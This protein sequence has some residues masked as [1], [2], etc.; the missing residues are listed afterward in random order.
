MARPK[1]KVLRLPPAE[2]SF[3]ELNDSPEILV[4]VDEAHRSHTSALHANLMQA[5]PNCA[6]IGFTGTPILKK[7]KKRTQDIFGPFIDCYTIKQSEADGATV[8]IIYEGRTA[9]GAVADGRSLDQ[10]FEDLFRDRTPKELTAIQAKYATAGRVLEAPKLIEAKARNMLRHYVLTVLPNGFKAQVVAVSRRAAVRYREALV[11]AHSELLQQVETLS[12]NLLALDADSLE[13]Q[14]AET[15][16]LVRAHAQLERLRKME[17]AAIISGDHNDQD[18]SWREWTGK[19]KQELRI[20]RFKKPFEHK[21]PEKRDG[22]AFLCVKSMLLVGFDAPIEQV[23]YIDRKLWDHELLQAIARVN[24]TATKKKCG[25]VVDYIG[26]GHHLKEALDAYSQKDIEGALTDITE[27]LPKLRDRHQRVLQIFKDAGIK[28]I[29]EVDDCVEAL[30]NIKTRAAFV[31]ALRQFLESLDI[32]MPRP[33]ALPYLRDA[34]ILGFICQ[35]ARNLYRDSR[36]NIMGVADKVRRLIDE[37][38]VSRGIDPKVPPISIT[39]A[40]FKTVVRGHK[41]SRSKAAEMEHALRY[42]ITRHF[43][44]DPAFYKSLSERLERILQQFKADWDALIRDLGALVDQVQTGPPPDKAGLDPKTQA[45]FLRVILEELKA[46]KRSRSTA[47][48]T[49]KEPLSIA[50]LAELTI[51][52]VAHIR[53]EIRRVDFWRN[54]QAQRVLRS[55]IVARLDEK[56]LFP[57]SKLESIAD[58]LV[59]LAKARHMLLTA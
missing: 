6:K 41:T 58:R 16:F 40:N 5:L 44:E 28:S 48:S 24:R 57:Y 55:W 23:L 42:H 8:P 52:L 18:R 7:D 50:L 37:H 15:Q 14:D 27:E 29:Q 1:R 20:E 4:L 30:R 32:I 45:P 3:G 38:I 46:P 33:E 51:E 19:D 12:P 54:A 34:K 36:L 49:V 56:D 39:D 10:V 17:F 26:L 25:L 43:P 9:K 13:K 22:L 11:K 47:T 2:E 31:I 53:Q 21:D 59:E 35:A